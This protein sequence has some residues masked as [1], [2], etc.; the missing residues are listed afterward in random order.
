MEHKDGK[1]I[2]H[3]NQALRVLRLWYGYLK[4]TLESLGFKANPRDICVFIREA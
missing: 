4:A 2:V 3:L 1:M